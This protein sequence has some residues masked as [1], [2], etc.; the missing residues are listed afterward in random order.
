MTADAFCVFC[1]CR[2]MGEY[3]ACESCAHALHR[4][5]LAV[6]QDGERDPRLIPDL[7]AATDSTEVR[8]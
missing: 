8:T 6:L 4:R 2:P 3:P 5:S 1:G 7:V